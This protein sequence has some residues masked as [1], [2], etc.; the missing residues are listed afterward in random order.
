MTRY[1]QEFWINDDSNKAIIPIMRNGSSSIKQIL[2]KDKAWRESHTFVDANVKFYTV[3]RHPYKR[4]LSA[5][6][7]ELSDILD[8][9]KGRE[10]EVLNNYRHEWS[11]HPDKMLELRHM[12]GQM[13][14]CKGATE[15]GSNITIYNFPG[16][17]HNM[18]REVLGKTVHMPVLNTT[19]EHHYTILEFVENQSARWMEGW[20]QDRYRNDYE[21][22]DQ[23]LKADTLSIIS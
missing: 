15:S 21:I 22:W 12:I 2:S 8:K 10:R 1:S 16:N 23:L 18:M 3:W 19:K 17:L 5:I 13:E 20:H 7:R 9:H 6:G 11:N 4:F 14:T